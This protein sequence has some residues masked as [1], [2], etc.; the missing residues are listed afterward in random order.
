MQQLYSRL[1][2]RSWTQID[3][4]LLPHRL[5]LLITRVC[6]GS[7]QLRRHLLQDLCGTHTVRGS[8]FSLL[9][10]PVWI[11]LK[12]CVNIASNPS[13]PVIRVSLPHLSNLC[14]TVCF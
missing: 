8:W 10:E 1:R 4:P 11:E 13:G 6:T 5:P 14:N 7:A 9:E 12:P 2:N 3:S